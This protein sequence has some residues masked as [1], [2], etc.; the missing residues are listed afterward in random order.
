VGSKIVVRDSSN[1]ST[2]VV[3]WGELGAWEVGNTVK[4]KGKV[5]QFQGVKYLANKKIERELNQHDQ[6]KYHVTMARI[7]FLEA[8]PVSLE[9]VKR[10]GIVAFEINQAILKDF[11][12]SHEIELSGKVGE[13]ACTINVPA[14]LVE[15]FLLGIDPN[16][17]IGK[18]YHMEIEKGAHEAYW[19]LQF[20]QQ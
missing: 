5:S 11:E 8:T 3:I 10:K 12:N 1:V 13:S 19:L 17:L 15:S 20:H 9:E 4:I 16:D 6:G 2:E 7:Q 14:D 18:V